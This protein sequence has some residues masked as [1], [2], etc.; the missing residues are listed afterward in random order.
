MN[1]FEKVIE[2]AKEAHSR[3]SFPEA[4]EEKMLQAIRQATDEGICSPVLVGNADD[5]A[6]AAGEFGIDI[7]DMELFDSADE[8]ALGNLIERYVATNEFLSTKTMRRKSK[9][10]MYV[11]LMMTSLGDTDATFAGLSHSTGDVILGAQTV[12]GMADGV[13]SVSSMGIWELSEDVVEG[14]ALGH[15]DAAVNPDPSAEQLADT[16]ICAAD[17]MR[18]LLGVEPRVAMLSFSTDG[19]TEHPLTEK[20]VKAVAIANERRPDL[21]ID[22][23][24]QF[25]AAINPSTAAKKV[26]RES[27]VA[28]RANFVVFPDLNAGN[29]G[30]KLVQQLARVNAPGPFLLGFKKIVGDCSR[31]APIGELVG[32]IAACSVR[33]QD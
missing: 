26:K 2:R 27:E 21:K 1:I 22:G 15:G 17:A 19:S 32:N 3:I 7:S 14:G 12:I 6:S 5:I 10:P 23:E 25:D 30:V 20:V 28:G 31:G 18:Q 4:T 8:E 33:A 13:E 29:I 16:A 9:D 11:A 24:F